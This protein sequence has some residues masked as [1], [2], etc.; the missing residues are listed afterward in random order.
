MIPTAWLYKLLGAALAA[1]AILWLVQSR[2]GWRQKSRA[3]AALY[4]Q[5]E[6]AHAATVANY[7][8]AADEARRQDAANLA[9]VEAGQAQ[10]NERTANDFETRIA[11]ARALA[12]RLRKQAAAATANPGDGGAA[13]VP[14]IPVAAEGA[15]QG[16]G[17]NGLPDSDA[18]IATEQA[19]QLDELI[20]WTRR[21]GAFDAD[22]AKAQPRMS[23]ETTPSP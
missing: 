8:A 23:L 10:I 6:A 11:S 2:D 18:L 19:I 14:G 12:D 20:K 16:A 13:P 5:G 22:A 21:Q 17:E 15:S 9:R 4:R 3:N 7:R 1:A